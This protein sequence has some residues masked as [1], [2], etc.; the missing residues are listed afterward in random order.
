M[1]LYDDDFE[2]D[3]LTDSDSESD[4]ETL[5]DSKHQPSE[6]K[7]VLAVSS[8]VPTIPIPK[9]TYNPKLSSSY[10]Q[11][12]VQFELDT[13]GSIVFSAHDK[14]SIVLFFE[15]IYN[16]FSIA[17]EAELHQRRK[18]SDTIVILN[19]D[20]DGVMLAC[21]DMMSV[22]RAR[23]LSTMVRNRA[24][25]LLFE[26]EHQSTFVRTKSPSIMEFDSHN[27]VTLT[28]LDRQLAKHGKHT[29]QMTGRRPQV[30]KT[31]VNFKTDRMREKYL[32]QQR[33]SDK[34]YQQKKRDRYRHLA[35]NVYTPNKREL[36][37]NI[38]HCPDSFAGLE[39]DFRMSECTLVFG[40]GTGANSLNSVKAQSTFGV[41]FPLNLD[42]EMRV[43]QITAKKIKVDLI[44]K[45]ETGE[46]YTSI[47]ECRKDHP[48]I[49][50]LINKI[51]INNE[52]EFQIMTIQFDV[53]MKRLEA[54]SHAYVVLNIRHC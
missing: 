29:S 10:V 48:Q 51:S 7:Q 53:M 45:I 8:S 3:E 12:Q 39:L 13:F 20:L 30:F 9:F 43:K 23:T 1:E 35:E 15:R 2:E 14:E 17:N 4:G 24:L 21:L 31:S 49:D 41:E 42:I 36:E 22:D 52:S 25:E 11:Q 37:R 19:I 40:L 28:D 38:M 26:P 44:Q 32:E 5:K 46:F 54:P 47:E 50:V 27:V 33:T 16:P 18:M 6:S 34:R